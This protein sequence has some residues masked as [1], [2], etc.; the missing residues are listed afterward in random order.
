M[1]SPKVPQV[2]QHVGWSDQPRSL[3]WALVVALDLALALVREGE[4]EQ[5]REQALEQ[6]QCP[7]VGRMGVPEMVAGMH[8]GLLPRWQRHQPLHQACP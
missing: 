3:C 8:Q 4:Q 5:G 1:V 6:V 2:E 7:W